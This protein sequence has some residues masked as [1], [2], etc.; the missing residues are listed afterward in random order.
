[1]SPPPL[2]PKK[3][4]EEEMMS[5][6]GSDRTL[7]VKLNDVIFIK[8]CVSL[9]KWHI[10]TTKSKAYNNKSKSNANAKENASSIGFSKD[11]S[12]AASDH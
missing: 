1:M 2:P 3:K 4:N 11:E 9:L 7:C 12:M 8:L 10:D 5:S 6:F